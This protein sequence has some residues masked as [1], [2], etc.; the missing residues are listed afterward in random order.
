MH[1]N[2]TDERYHEAL[3][4]LAIV[5]LMLAG[6]S[7]RVANKAWPLRSLVLWLLRRAEARVQDFA[8]RAGAPSLPVQCGASPLG[9][10]AARLAER[11][12]ALAAGFFTLSRQT[13]RGVWPAQRNGSPSRLADYRAV[14]GPGPCFGTLHRSL[15]DTS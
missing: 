9:G 15:I 2:A 6:V 11:F 10:E 8:R 13:A 4:R 12:R 1:W 3:R 7:E 14:I 5:L